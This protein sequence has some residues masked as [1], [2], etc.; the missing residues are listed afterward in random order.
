MRL[1]G[2]TSLSP[3]VIRRA[4]A[5][6]PGDCRSTLL[7]LP[8]LVGDW[9]WAEHK[10]FLADTAQVRRDAERIET[11]Y[12]IHGYPDATVTPRMHRRDDRV[13]VEFLI[14]EGRPFVV[15]RITVG[16]LDTIPGLALP[17]RLPLRAGEPY[18]LPRLEATE[19]VIRDALAVTGR[20]H[21]RI[22]VGGEVNDGERTATLEIDVTPGPRAT[23]GPIT[24]EA[25]APIGEGDVRPFIAFHTGEPY[26]PSALEQTERSLYTLPIVARAVV[27]PGPLGDVIAVR[28]LVEPRPVH[29]LDVEGTLSST[30]CLELAAFW[31]H[32]HFLGGAR[33]VS[34]GGSLSNVFASGAGGSFPC[35]GTG[36]G[37]FAELDHTLEIDLRQPGFLGDARNLLDAGVFQRRESSPDAYIARGTGGRVQVARQVD[38]RLSTRVGYSAQRNELFAAAVYFCGN[39]GVCTADGVASLS[40][41]HALAPA[42]AIALWESSPG[43][44]TAR[45]PDTRP[46]APWRGLPPPMARFTARFEIEGAGSATGSDYSYR[47]VLADVGATYRP[48]RLLELAAHVRAGALGGAAVLPPQLR[49]YSGGVNTVRGVGQNLLGPQLLV[50][51]SGDVAAGVCPP[52]TADCVPST[53]D[54]NTVRVRPAG[55]HRV[56]DGGIEVRLWLAERLQAVGF[57]DAGRL[58]RNTAGALE[59][60]GLLG[61]TSESRVTPG[62]G[63][64]LLTDIGPIRLDV[65]YDP[66]GPRIYPVLVGDGDGGV[67]LAGNARF[68][69]YGWDQPGAFREFT[70]RLQLQMAIGQAF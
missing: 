17:A 1:V 28:V 48:G 68:D 12:E 52:A 11:L 23:V 70:R 57:L 60:G 43:V 16:G 35:G 46:G 8:C 56:I 47:R 13:D 37:E 14:D 65:G 49:L 50:S 41:P 66:G 64:R 21:P 31:R 20:I 3:E 32:R 30:D 61:E 62:L 19:R 33:V 38:A 6:R 29:G 10:T 42:E 2:A 58:S 25:V 24:I 26:R 51:R 4:I 18:A 44:Q 59:G 55:G 53:I 27:T 7:A 39:Y 15:R 9:D 40:G 54:P 22:E 45:P 34:I 5:T 63:I 69:P 36:T 67:R